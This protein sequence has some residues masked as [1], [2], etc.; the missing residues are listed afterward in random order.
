MFKTIAILAVCVVTGIN[1]PAQGQVKK[2]SDSEREVFHLRNLEKDFGYSQA[3]R[4]GNTIHISGSVSMNDTGEVL[5]KGDMKEQ[6]KNA[7]EDIRKTL[8]HFGADYGD[9]VKETIFTTDMDALLS[10]TGVRGKF[11]EGYEYP[12][13]TWV[14]VPRLVSPDFLVEVEVVAVLKVKKRGKR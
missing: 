12:A 5:G 6:L 7:L 13:A 14:A 1:D 11:Y 10:A 3:V 2:R 9:V 4:V 8:A